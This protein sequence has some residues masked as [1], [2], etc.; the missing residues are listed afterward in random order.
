MEGTTIAAAEWGRVVRIGSHAGYGEFVVVG[1]PDGQSTRYSHLQSG[2][3]QV[4]LSE[5]VTPGRT[6]ASMGSTGQATGP[7]LDFEVFDSHGKRFDPLSI[8]PP[9]PSEMAIGRFVVADPVTAALSNAVP[10]PTTPTSQHASAP[11]KE[12]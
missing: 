5:I 8:L 1:H 10:V 2:S 12:E 4:T 7:H 11:R 9:V 3:I 6:I